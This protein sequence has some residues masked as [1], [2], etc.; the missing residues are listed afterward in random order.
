MYSHTVELYAFASPVIF[1]NSDTLYCTVHC[2]VQRP[3]NNKFVI[4]TATVC[5]ISS[6]VFHICQQD[7]QDIHVGHQACQVSIGKYNDYLYVVKTVLPQR[8]AELGRVRHHRVR[9]HRVRLHR[10]RLHK[11]RLYGGWLGRRWGNSSHKL[12]RTCWFLKGQSG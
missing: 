10:A 8:Q 11:V 1:S 2:T 5:P 7:W 12:C 6:G 4:K 9:L 3:L